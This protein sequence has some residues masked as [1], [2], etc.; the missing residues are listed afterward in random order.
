MDFLGKIRP[1]LTDVEISIGDIFHLDN[2]R[3]ILTNLAPMLED[4]IPSLYCSDDS[5]FSMVKEQLLS[6]NEKLAKL[7]M[8]QINFILVTGF[9][10]HFKDIFWFIF[11]NGTAR[12]SH[13]HYE[14]AGPAG[15]RWAKIFASRQ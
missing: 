6:E 8:L 7:K 5:G 13:I 4:G 11:R 3:T 1:L 10:A 14:L 15:H 9:F 12:N 2:L